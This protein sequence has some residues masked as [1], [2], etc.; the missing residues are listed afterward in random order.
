MN[1]NWLKETIDLLDRNKQPSLIDNMI[2]MKIEQINGQSI[3]LK[4][5]HNEK[6]VANRVIIS[7]MKLGILYQVEFWMGSLPTS[8]CRNL[9]IDEVKFLINRYTILELV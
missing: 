7:P 8:S 1:I 6:T 2:T 4:V 3:S 9:T 5:R